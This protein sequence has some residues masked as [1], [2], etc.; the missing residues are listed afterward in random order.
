MKK[1]SLGLLITLLFTTSFSTLLVANEEEKLSTQTTTSTTSFQQDSTDSTTENNYSPSDSSSSEAQSSVT[2]ENDETISSDVTDSSSETVE[3]N[4]TSESITSSETTSSIEQ[5]TLDTETITTPELSIMPHVQKKG[6]LEAGNAGDIIGTT[7]KGLQLEAIKIQLQDTHLSGSIEYT[8]H[9]RQKGWLQ[10]WAKD[11]NPSGAVGQGLQIEALKVRLTGEL[12]KNFDIYY[13]AHIQSY[14]WLDWAKN[15]EEAG[16]QGYAKRVEAIRIII[17]EKGATPPG[18]TDNPFKIAPPMIFTSS[19][20]SKIGWQHSVPAN[21]TSGTVGKGLQLEAFKLA[22]SNTTSYQGALIYQAHVEKRGW[23][24]SVSNGEIAGTIGNKL[25]LQ[26]ISINLTGELADHYDIYYRVHSRTI[27]WL[28]WAKNGE[29]A[30][31]VGMS[32]RAEAMQVVVLEKG[33]TPTNYSKNG[34][35]LRG[36][37]QDSTPQG[38]FINQIISD[39]QRVAPKAGLYSSVMLAQAILESGYGQSK[40]SKDA[41]N[42]FGIKFIVGEDEKKYGRYDIVSNE[43]INGELVPILSP[44]RKYNNFLSSA[45]DNALKLTNGLSWNPLHYQNTWKINAK[46]YQDATAA[47]Q[48]AGYATS[49]SYA[50]TLNSVIR[51]WRLDQFD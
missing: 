40:L 50:S 10:A 43:E 42:Y 22:L 49:S 13:Q 18:K 27:G 17:V 29:K 47:L 26:A 28:D 15:G 19:H 30:G 2:P 31:T 8:T 45:Q 23:L 46:T 39:V 14:G 11:G 32:L 33:Q 37:V 16:S 7:G 51:N 12:E 48:K 6:W 35:S 1:L 20:V 9:V 4:G 38:K 24:T 44:F 21:M 34:L 36:Q 5:A 25:A 41:N 3:S